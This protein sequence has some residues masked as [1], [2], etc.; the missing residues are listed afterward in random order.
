MW[1]KSGIA[2][3][4]RLESVTHVGTIEFPSESGQF[5]WRAYSGSSVLS[6]SQTNYSSALDA[7]AAFDALVAEPK[8]S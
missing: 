1:I 6:D 7:V 3:R 5:K 4:I 2:S 8:P